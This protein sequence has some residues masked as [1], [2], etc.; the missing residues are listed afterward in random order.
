[1]TTF[2]SGIVPEC[3]ARVRPTHS[4][5]RPLSLVIDFDAHS[6]LAREVAA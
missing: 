2:E 3:S 1:M 6:L 5:H 4:H